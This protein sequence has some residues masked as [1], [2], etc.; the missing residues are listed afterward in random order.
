[1]WIMS[2]E[3]REIIC[4]LGVFINLAFKAR[5]IKLKYTNTIISQM[6]TL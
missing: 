2:C 3:H 4:A 6:Y 5:D 1:M